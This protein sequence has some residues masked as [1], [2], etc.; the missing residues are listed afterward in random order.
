MWLIWSYFFTLCLLHDHY[1][2]FAFIMRLIWSYFFT[3]CLSLHYLKLAC[4]IR[5]I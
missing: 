5:L 1:L 4:I 2:K 3:F